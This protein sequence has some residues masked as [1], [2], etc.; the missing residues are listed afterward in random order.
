MDLWG[1]VDGNVEIWIWRSGWFVKFKS[2]PRGNA[3]GFVDSFYISFVL[4]MY[5]YH[6]YCFSDI[7]VSNVDGNVKIW[8]WKV[9]FVK[10]KSARGNACGFVG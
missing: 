1:N 8:I 4:Y 5:I 7:H 2:A 3:C 9:R 10:F 6:L